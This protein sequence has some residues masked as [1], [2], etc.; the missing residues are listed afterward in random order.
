MNA[1]WEE[2]VWCVK[3]PPTGRLGLACVVK[4]TY[5]VG[6][7]A[8]LS[9]ADQQAPVV[10]DPELTTDHE[11]GC[12]VLLDDTDALSRKEAT[13]IV[14]RGR[15][16]AP[17]PG[18][19]HAVAGFAVGEVAR[20]LRVTGEREVRVGRD[21]AV[22][23]SDPRP[24]D[25]VHLDHHHAYG[26]L[27]MYARERMAPP[28][29][30]L[31]PVREVGVFAYPRNSVGL[32][33][34]VDLDRSRADGARLPLV[35]DPEDLL[36][37]E[38]FFVKTPAAW[39]DAPIPGC[40]GW[41][42]YAWYPRI[43]RMMGPVLRHTPPERPIREARWPDGDDLP[44]IQH[45]TPGATHARALQGASPGLA[46]RR[47]RGDEPVILRNL[48]RSR[49]DVRFELPGEAPRVVVRVPDVK[50]L[51]PQTVLQT[52]RLEPEHDR[53]SLTWCGVVPLLAR[54]DQD[55]LDSVELQVSW[56]RV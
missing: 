41:V 15:A 12:Q 4:R 48:H 35:E 21:G 13:D 2:Q 14:L 27:D 49:E 55:F 36:T 29:S 56:V 53:L 43:F 42:H 44:H 38:R 7:G 32:G 52:L 20:Q 45:P 33:Y 40:W 51:S 1:S 34:F 22:R 8:R 11:D 10:I 54:V 24:F 6:P 50:E 28:S 19:T 37:P 23:F 47:L 5:S 26:G 18:L 39:L 9:V 16:Y 25:A 46:V 3:I 17:E 30:P 31:Y